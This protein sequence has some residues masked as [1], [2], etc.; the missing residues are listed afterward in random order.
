MI[1]TKARADR[2]EECEDQHVLSDKRRPAILLKLAG[3]EFP[4]VGDSDS[5][6]SSLSREVWDQM[7]PRIAD[8][9]NTVVHEST[10][11]A[12]VE[13]HYGIPPASRLREV[14]GVP[15]PE[16][17]AKPQRLILARQ[18]LLPKAA[19]RAARQ[20]SKVVEC[21]LGNRLQANPISS[22]AGR[23][24]KE[25]FLLHKGPYRIRKRIPQTAYVLQRIDEGFERGT[26]H[27]SH[28]KRYQPPPGV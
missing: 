23:Q 22:A 24:T 2:Q 16:P 10:C 21:N 25:I 8:M 27:G 1:E 14:L 5:Q 17:S 15:P 13:M 4:A 6:V 28:L 3:T 12:P 9:R 11:L 19:R 7:L 26:F 18:C 20:K